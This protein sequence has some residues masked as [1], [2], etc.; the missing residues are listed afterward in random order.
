MIL[1][2]TDKTALDTDGFLI[3]P[4]FMGPALLTRLRERV[5]ELVLN[6]R[7]PPHEDPYGHAA[8]VRRAGL[9]P[10]GQSDPPRAVPRGDGPRDPQETAARRST[11]SPK[12]SL[13]R[14]ATS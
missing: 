1:S 13:P 5:K 12:Q 10:E 8:D 7:R 6:A 11:T 9:E 2:A 3:L 14:C 4:D